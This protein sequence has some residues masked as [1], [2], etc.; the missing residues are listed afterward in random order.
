MKK[1][2]QLFKKIVLET[3]EEICG[4]KK[5]GPMCKNTKWWNELVKTVVKEK[6]RAW[7]RLLQTGTRQML[8]EYKK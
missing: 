1:M 3:S 4:K 7:K 8:E 6:K 5:E 2:W